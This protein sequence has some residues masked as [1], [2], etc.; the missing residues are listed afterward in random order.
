M[1]PQR[2]YI[3]ECLFFVGFTHTVADERLNGA[4]VFSMPDNLG[5][6]VKF[7]QQAFDKHKFAGHSPEIKR[8]FRVQ[9]DDVSS[10]G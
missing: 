1:H 2:I 3:G 5:V 10:C 8:P 9:A 6:D 7:A 4:F